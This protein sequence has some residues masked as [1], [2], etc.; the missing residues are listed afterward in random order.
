VC[1]YVCV[2]RKRHVRSVQTLYIRH[3]GQSRSCEFS[4]RDRYVTSRLCFPQWWN[5]TTF[6]SIKK[7][8]VSSATDIAPSN[9]HG[10]RV[11]I[12]IFLS[13]SCLGC[14]KIHQPYLLRF[15]PSKS[16]SIFPRQRSNAKRLRVN[17]FPQIYLFIH[18]IT[19]PY[20]DYFTSNLRWD[21]T[22]FNER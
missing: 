12:S 4:S 22:M 21:R 6:E 2:S 16:D 1:V 15:S 5:W 9:V 14:L 8:G 13:E 17:G 20:C 3:R 10:K 11:T 7:I 19:N 18:Y